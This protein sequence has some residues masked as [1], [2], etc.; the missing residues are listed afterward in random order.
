MD[1]IGGPSGNIGDK[2]KCL[3]FVLTFT[4]SFYNVC[5]CVPTYIQF[6]YKIK[7]VALSI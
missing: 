5:V 3:V 2:P 1:S 6:P 4:L 7:S